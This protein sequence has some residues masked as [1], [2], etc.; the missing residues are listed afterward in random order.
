MCHCIFPHRQSPSSS[1][2]WFDEPLW[3]LIRWSSFS[4]CVNTGALCLRVFRGVD[5]PYA[6]VCYSVMQRHEAQSSKQLSN[7]HRQGEKSHLEEQVRW[8][9]APVPQWHFHPGLPH[10]FTFMCCS[11]VWMSWG[12]SSINIKASFKSRLKSHVYRL[13]LMWCCLFLSL[14]AVPLFI[15]III[16]YCFYVSLRDVFFIAFIYSLFLLFWRYFCYNPR[17]S[18]VCF[19]C[20]DKIGKNRI[21]FISI[22]CH[23]IRYDTLLII[24]HWGNSLVTAADSRNE[25]DKRIEKIIRIKN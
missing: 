11:V 17:V 4:L 5:Y 14:I 10:S 20:Q 7:G 25:V 23:K 1:A 8:S 3:A 24:P 18:C 19:V 15:I 21:R 22:R 6:G 2:R 16:H 9:A 13:G 12:E